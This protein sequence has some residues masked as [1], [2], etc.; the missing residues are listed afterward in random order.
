MLNVDYD[1]LDGGMKEF[2]DKAYEQYVKDPSK[3][4]KELDKSFATF[5][6]LQP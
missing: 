5:Q 4:E 1:M 3:I 2:V 6:K